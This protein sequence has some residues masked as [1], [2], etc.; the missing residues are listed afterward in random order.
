[1][2]NMQ[3]AKF[4][5][6]IIW[7]HSVICARLQMPWKPKQAKRL[8]ALSVEMRCVLFNWKTQFA[9]HIVNCYENAVPLRAWSVSMK[10]EDI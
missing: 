3:V 10:T 8:D 5:I 2:S 9:S 1:M 6:L 4:N 7:I